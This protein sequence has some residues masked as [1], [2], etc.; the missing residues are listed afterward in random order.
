MNSCRFL[1]EKSKLT[2]KSS[3]LEGKEVTP[4]FFI[5]ILIGAF[6]CG[7]HDTS[8]WIFH[9]KKGENHASRSNIQLKRPMGTIVRQVAD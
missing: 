3:D 9:T 2:L 8:E 4:G 7:F 1:N 5:L 6:K